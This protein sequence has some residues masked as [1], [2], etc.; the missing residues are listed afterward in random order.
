MEQFLASDEALKR[1]PRVGDRLFVDRANLRQRG[2]R[3]V[4]LEWGD[5]R[6]AEHV[7][8]TASHSGG[9]RTRSTVTCAE[10]SLLQ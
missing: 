5:E 2:D 7:G 6:R 8:L 9:G 4:E 10:P 1:G 3:R